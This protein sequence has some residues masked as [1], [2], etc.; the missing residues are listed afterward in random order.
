MPSSERP[1]ILFLQT[2]NPGVCF[3]RMYQFAQKMSELNLAHCRMFPDYDPYRLASPNWEFKLDENIHEL[4]RHVSWADIVI[5]QYICSPEGLSVIQAIKETRPVLMECDDYFKQVPYQSIAYD[6]NKPGSNTDLWATRQLMESSGVIVSTPWLAEQYK[7]YNQNIAC[8]PNCIDFDLWDSFNPIP[9]DLLRVG[10]IGGATHNGDLRLVKNA[11]FAL[12]REYDNVEIHIV[13]A[14]PPDDWPKHDRLHMINKWATIDKYAQ[15][16]KELSFDIGI[17]PLRDNL[18]NRGKSNLRGLEYAA[19]KIPFVASPVVPF[20]NGLGSFLAR[21]EDEW[22]ALLENLILN[23]SLRKI[24]G[25]LNYSYI[26]EHYNLEKVAV[27]YA[28]HIG[29]Y[30]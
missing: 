16:V 27:D 17:A 4:E 5:C 22:I 19:C 20:K 3:Y 2:I 8:M 14:P 18:F 28:Q 23:E 6:E 25:N 12:L 10:F 26:K 15:H 1:K 13:S 30:L 21:D 9:H 29:R 11:L 24:E 7:E